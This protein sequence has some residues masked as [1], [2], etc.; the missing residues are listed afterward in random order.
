MIGEASRALAESSHAFNGDS[1]PGYPAGHGRPF[2]QRCTYLK[3][4][5]AISVLAVCIRQLPIS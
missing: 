1:L 4:R 3:K 2:C 5:E